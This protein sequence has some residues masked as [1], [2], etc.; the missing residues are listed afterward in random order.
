MKMIFKY[1]F[2]EFNNNTR[3]QCSDCKRWFESESFRS[4]HTCIT[5]DA[6]AATGRSNRWLMNENDNNSNNS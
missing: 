5:A 6:I 4:S 3:I 1:G 2:L